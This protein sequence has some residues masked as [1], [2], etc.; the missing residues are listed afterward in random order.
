MLYKLYV[1]HKVLKPSMNVCHYWLYTIPFHNNNTSSTSIITREKPDDATVSISGLLSDKKYGV[2][3]TGNVRV[4]T[5][6]ILLLYILLQPKYSSSSNSSSSSSSSSNSN[7]SSSSSSSSSSKI[8]ER[9]NILVE[10]LIVI[11]ISY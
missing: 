6:E 9:K 7:S 5:S 4:W 11:K 1:K 10:L 3:N 8:I 2:D